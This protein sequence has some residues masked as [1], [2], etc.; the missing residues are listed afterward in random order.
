M[1]DTVSRMYHCHKLHKNITV[2][3]E[4]EVSGN[5]RR[6]LRCS[7]P[8]HQYTDRTPHCDG[9]NDLGFQC[10]YTKSQ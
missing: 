2:Y 8:Y 5:T 6:I 1:I 7:C 9:R 3:E 4:Y 10:G